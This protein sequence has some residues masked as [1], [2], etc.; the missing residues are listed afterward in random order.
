MESQY[1]DEAF[2]EHVYKK[3]V[4]SF[5]IIALI[6]L[7]SKFYWIISLLWNIFKRRTLDCGT[8]TACYF[9]TIHKNACKILA[10]EAHSFGQRAFIGKVAMNQYSPDHYM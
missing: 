2:A 4:V 3:V 5:K 6:Q 9:G 7:L 8:T 1:K 10:D